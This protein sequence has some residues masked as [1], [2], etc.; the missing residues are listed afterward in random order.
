MPL[1]YSSTRPRLVLGT[2]D[3]RRRS[4]ELH[5]LE[6]HPYLDGSAAPQMEQHNDREA[7]A[8]LNRR[9]GEVA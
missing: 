6:G 7:P 3:H 8:R 5:P 4:R 9:A 2:F 1:F